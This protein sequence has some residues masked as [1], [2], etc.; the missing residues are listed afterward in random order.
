MSYPFVEVV[1]C[2]SSHRRVGSRDRKE[3]C[4]ETGLKRTLTRAGRWRV[5]EA[6]E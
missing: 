2:E 3:S 6:W 4:P 1:E 5:A